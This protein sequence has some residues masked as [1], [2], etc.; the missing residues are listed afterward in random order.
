MSVMTKILGLAGAALLATSVAGT[1]ATLSLTGGSY[2]P[3]KATFNPTTAVAGLAAGVN[4]TKY[5]V[6]NNNDPL[7]GGL[8]LLGQAKVTMTFVAKE[9]GAKDYI[10][11][12][13]G[14]QKLQNKTGTEGAS[15]SFTQSTLNA[16]LKILFTTGLFGN[17]QPTIT[18]GGTSTDARMALAFSDVF[19]GGQSV[20]ALFD[21]GAP[22][23]DPKRNPDRDYDDMIVRIDVQSVPLPAGGLLLLT[24][25]GG[26]VVARRRKSL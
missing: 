7:G 1:A 24:G 22:A 6:A 10:I 14:G 11:E 5:A 23:Q 12:T 25:L 26:L 19:N 8:N 2:D 9:A 21:D 18:N 4:V 15:I 3:L 13:V 17:P 16:F 20:Y